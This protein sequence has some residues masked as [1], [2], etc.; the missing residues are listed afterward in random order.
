MKKKRQ[1]TNRD[2]EDAYVDELV[3]EGVEQIRREIDAEVLRS[4]LKDIG[5]HEVILEPMT[6]ETSDSIDAWVKQCIKGRSHWTHGL[7]WLFEDD[8]D[9]MWFKLRW[10]HEKILHA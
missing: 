1:L 2:P 3:K 9:A 5:W 4:M 7:V 8:R 10:A 6:M